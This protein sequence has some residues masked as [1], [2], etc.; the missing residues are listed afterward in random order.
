MQPGRHGI[1]QQFRAETGNQLEDQH[2]QRQRHPQQPEQQRHATPEPYPPSRARGRREWRGRFLARGCE[3][4]Q[5]FRQLG[6]FRLH[7]RHLHFGFAGGRGARFHQRA[8][9]A[10]H[11]IRIGPGRQERRALFLAMLIKNTF[12]VG[13][14]RDHGRVP[15]RAA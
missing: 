6:Q 8:P 4:A 7:P 5:C 13:I 3:C 10:K 11:L 12:C 2:A 15:F 9:I 1:K 14:P